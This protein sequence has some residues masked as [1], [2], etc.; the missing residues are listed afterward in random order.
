MQVESPHTCPTCIM[1]VN[2]YPQHMYTHTSHMTTG[3]VP[4]PST[5]LTHDYRWSPLSQH[6]KPEPPPPLEQRLQNGET[7]KLLS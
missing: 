2:I 6:S 3:G 1:H 7:R 4:Y 5:H